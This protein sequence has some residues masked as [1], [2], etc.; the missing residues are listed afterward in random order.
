MLRPARL[1]PTARNGRVATDPVLRAARSTRSVDE[2]FR[3]R[4]A[5]ERNQ[6]AEHERER[7]QDD[8][9]GER[10]RPGASATGPASRQQSIQC[11]LDASALLVLLFAEPGADTVADVI[12]EG[13]AISTVNLA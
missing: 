2:I 7:S 11:V 5:G 4:P 6:M 10:A 13:A 12:A 1:P 3:M 9:A 8:V